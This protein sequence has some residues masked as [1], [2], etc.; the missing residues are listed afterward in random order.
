MFKLMT[1]LDISIVEP[2]LDTPLGI[3]VPEPLFDTPLIIFIPEAPLNF[4]LAV[5]SI[6]LDYPGSIAEATIGIGKSQ[7][8]VRIEA[9]LRVF[10]RESGARR[11]Y[12]EQKSQKQK[13]T[14][15]KKH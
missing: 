3:A 13:S 9:A 1:E 15:R 4:D 5:F 2:L 7:D 10:H 12:S 14:A 8:G 6:C 11:A